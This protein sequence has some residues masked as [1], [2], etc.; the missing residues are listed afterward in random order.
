MKLPLFSSHADSEPLSTSTPSDAWDTK[1]HKSSFVPS[2]SSPGRE[3]KQLPQ[4]FTGAKGEWYKN[5]V[6]ALNKAFY[7]YLGI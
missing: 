2:R 1:I 7:F 5:I 6:R 4:N 3:N